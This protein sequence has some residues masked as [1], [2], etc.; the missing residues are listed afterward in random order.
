MSNS[1]LLWLGGAAAAV[2]WWMS[3]RPWQ[4]PAS[5]EPYLPTIQAAAGMHGVPY[6]LLVRLLEQESGFRED[7]I[8]GETVS[9]AGAVG[10]AQLVPRWHPNVDPTDP[11]ESIYYAANYLADL[12]AAFGSWP[13]ALA[14]YNYGW[15]N[16]RE[17]IEQRGPAW[18]MFAPDETR[19][20]VA[21]IISD[22]AP[23]AAARA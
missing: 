9:S 15:G 20:Y 22:A 23:G 14:A 21:E 12:K 4:P 11:I 3:R 16:M 5:A 1:A 10:I 7:V 13:L 8:S 17:L 6:L 19:T 18:W 2:L